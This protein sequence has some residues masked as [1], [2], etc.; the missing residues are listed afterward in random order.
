MLG[1][2]IAIALLSAGLPDELSLVVGLRLSVRKVGD[3]D[4][5]AE[6]NSGLKPYDLHENETIR[7]NLFAILDLL[8]LFEAII[9]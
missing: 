5:V 2:D 3:L 6:S 8:I 4:S 9:K 7:L 1:S